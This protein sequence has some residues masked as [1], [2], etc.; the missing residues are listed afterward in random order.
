MIIEKQYICCDIFW[1]KNE[2][3]ILDDI[4]KILNLIYNC[5]FEHL[6]K[7]LVKLEKVNG[8]IGKEY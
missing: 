8:K 1:K 6:I 4:L 7:F 5:Q 2:K 3:W